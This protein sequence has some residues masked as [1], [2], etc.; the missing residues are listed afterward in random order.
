M[1][2]VARDIAGHKCTCVLRGVHGVEEEWGSYTLQ[3]LPGPCPTGALLHLPSS[4]ASEV[5]GQTPCCQHQQWSGRVRAGVTRVMPSHK[6][7]ALWP[8]Q[9]TST[10][11]ASVSL[12]VKWDYGARS[13]I[14]REGWDPWGSPGSFQEVHKALSFPPAYL[15]GQIFFIHF[16]QNNITSVW[17]CG[18]KSG[19]LLLSWPKNS[20]ANTLLGP[21]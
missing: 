3:G 14:L 12:S 9:G 4:T 20:E 6:S 18:R 15:W 17:M 19:C 11:L 16:S 7:R 10:L 1:C 13:A 5:R 2:C 8:G 21:P